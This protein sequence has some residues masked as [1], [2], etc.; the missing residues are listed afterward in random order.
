MTAARMKITF[1]IITPWLC[2]PHTLAS[3]GMNGEAAALTDAPPARSVFFR[4]LYTYLCVFTFPQ[5]H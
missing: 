1:I 3:D 5:S 4:E 2:A